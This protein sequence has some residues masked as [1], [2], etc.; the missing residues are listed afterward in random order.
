MYEAKL[1]LL[2]ELSHWRHY[3]SVK[4]S[5]LICNGNSFIFINCFLQPFLKNVVSTYSCFLNELF[6]LS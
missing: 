2:R 4:K 6:S 3:I 1:C 5:N